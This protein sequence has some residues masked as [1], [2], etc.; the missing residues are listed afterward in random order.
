MYSPERF[1]QN[2]RDQLHALIR[3]KPFATLIS[4]SENGLEANHL[5]FYLKVIKGKQVLQG[6]VAKANPL[7]KSTQEN[8]EVLVI[9]QGC[10]S[11]ISPSLYPAKQVHGK[12]VPTWNYQVVHV[13]G[14]MSYRHDEAW[15]LAMLNALTQ[16]QE[17]Q[18]A[19]P[20]AVSDAPECYLQTM[21]SAIVGLEIEISSISGKWK[22]SQNQTEENRQG[23][24]SGLSSMNDGESK[25][26][27]ELVDRAD[28]Q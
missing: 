2:N 7:W 4:H 17:A 24:I 26:M 28:R 23:V 25:R 27:A 21:M 18:Q 15:K 9:F 5:P 12:V 13:Q 16:Q 3:A 22:L 14:R 6:H 10:D 11:Y 1:K 8:A 20:W 19:Q